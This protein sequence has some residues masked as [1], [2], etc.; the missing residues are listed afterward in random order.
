MHKWIPFVVLFVAVIGFAGP[1]ISSGTVPQTGTVT[2]TPVTSD[3]SIPS[4]DAGVLVFQSRPNDIVP[5]IFSFI[6]DGNLNFRTYLGAGSYWPYGGS[7]GSKVEC[8]FPYNWNS[9]T[10]YTLNH[11]PVNP[12]GTA[13][14]SPWDAG[15]YLGRVPT[16]LTISGGSVNVGAGL[17]MGT[18]TQENIW[19]GNSAGAGGFLIWFGFGL[20]DTKATS[21]TWIG[22]FDA[23]PTVTLSA[24]PSAAL[25]SIYIG[26]D[27]A[28]TELKACSNDG[29]GTATCSPSLGA[30][31]PCN[32]DGAT[33]DVWFW[34]KPNA[35]SVEYYIER[36][37][38]PATASGSMTSDLPSKVAL[39]NWQAILGTGS[40]NGTAVRSTIRGICSI[41]NY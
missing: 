5:A 17:T 33:Y 27:A 22:L 37:D 39:L 4:Q 31:F 7:G 36:L 15:T 13:S 19:R 18:G 38:T 10:Y 1:S 32:T 12:I 23:V 34:A 35:D 14:A 6:E 9:G 16:M 25:N 24:D 41:A 40:S 29:S 20:A 28:D 26:C 8:T 21:R 30:S 2:L 11:G 3:P